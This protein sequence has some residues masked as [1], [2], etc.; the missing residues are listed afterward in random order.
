MTF[1]LGTELFCIFLAY[2]R[3]TLKSHMTELHWN[4]QDCFLLIRSISG[5][6]T[7]SVWMVHSRWRLIVVKECAIL[8]C[9]IAHIFKTSGW[10]NI[11]FGSQGDIGIIHSF[12]DFDHGMT[13]YDLELFLVGGCA[14][15]WRPFTFELKTLGEKVGYC[16][17]LPSYFVLLGASYSVYRWEQSLQY[18]QDGVKFI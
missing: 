17:S 2:D 16:Q 6:T 8:V 11:T 18:F 10:N 5:S 13:S 9:P 12:S 4:P 1:D 7:S 14:S 3:I 15:A